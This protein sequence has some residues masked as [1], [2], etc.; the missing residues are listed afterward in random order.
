VGQQ[1][2]QLNICAVVPLGATLDAVKIT[3]RKALRIV[4]L[5]SAPLLIATSA[6]AANEFGLQIHLIW[7]TDG[8]KPDNPNL[9]DVE[10]GIRKYLQKF[11]WKN[12]WEVS[13]HAAAIAP[14]KSKRV[15]VSKHCEVE[16]AHLEKQLFEVKLYGEKKLVAHRRMESLAS[17]RSLVI[18]GDDKNESA[19]F[20]VINMPVIGG[21][22]AKTPPKRSSP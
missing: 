6:F 10:P 12:Y 4:F 14:S 21:E 1:H 19:W 15:V 8:D 16:I 3:Q 2:G 18:A 20:V 11:K 22:A 13:R 5:A 17:G 9:K 7:G